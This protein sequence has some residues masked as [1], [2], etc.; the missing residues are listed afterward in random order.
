MLTAVASRCSKMGFTECR[1]TGVDAPDRPLLKRRFGEGHGERFLVRIQPDSPTD[2]I[3]P[4]P[5]RRRASVGPLPAEKRVP[6]VEF[7]L[8][9][10]GIDSE[11]PAPTGDQ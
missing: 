9:Q 10:T 4:S 6:Q 2:V 8:G 1:P 11:A 5:A 3:T 7:P